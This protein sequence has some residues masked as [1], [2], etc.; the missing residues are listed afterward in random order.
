MEKKFK[1]QMDLVDET[2]DIKQRI[3]FLGEVMAAIALREETA[4]LSSE[5]LCGLYATFKDL[6]NQCESLS[7]ALNHDFCIILDKTIHLDNFCAMVESG[8]KKGAGKT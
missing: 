8:I 3:V 7:D 4:G 2:Q 1:S 6:E 5:G